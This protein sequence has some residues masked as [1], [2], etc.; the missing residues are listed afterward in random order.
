MVATASSSSKCPDEKHQFRRQKVTVTRRYQDVVYVR[1]NL[2]DKD[3]LKS[4]DKVI[5]GGA[6]LLNEA[7]NDLPVEPAK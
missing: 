1:A 4:G 6:V 7:M 3:A 5:A 2:T